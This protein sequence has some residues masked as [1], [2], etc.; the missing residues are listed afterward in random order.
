MPVYVLGGV[1]LV[2]VE[3]KEPRLH[4]RSI[5]DNRW[6]PFPAPFGVCGAGGCWRAVAVCW[7][8][9]CLYLVV[10]VGNEVSCDVGVTL[11]LF[12]VAFVIRW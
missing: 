12:V 10:V 2:V 1:P 5:S 8:V 7:T 4:F 11:V 9:T 6:L 3:V